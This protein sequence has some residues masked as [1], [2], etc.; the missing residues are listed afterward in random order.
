[1]DA[2][3]RLR[4]LAAPLQGRR[5]GV[6]LVVRLLQ[7]IFNHVAAHSRDVLFALVFGLGVRLDDLEDVAHV[8]VIFHTLIL[9]GCREC[10]VRRAT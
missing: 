6:L 7:D 2:L 9:T 8:I 1:M 3:L 5:K 10:H 4:A